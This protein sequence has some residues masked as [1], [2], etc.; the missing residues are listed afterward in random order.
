MA[1]R[2]KCG[3][4]VEQI[5]PTANTTKKEK[6]G[7]SIAETDCANSTKAAKIWFISAAVMMTAIV[8]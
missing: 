1:E 7:R 3:A 4:R 6:I 5:A 8:E 2:Q